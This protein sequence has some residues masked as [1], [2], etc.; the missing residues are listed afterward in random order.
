MFF[1]GHCTGCFSVQC[2]L[3]PLGQHYTRFLSVQCCPK[4]IMTTLH[5][6]FSMSNVVWSLSSNIAHAIYLFNVVPRVLR[7]H[8]KWFFW[9]K[10]GT[11]I[12]IESSIRKRCKRKI[13][14]Y[15]KP[16]KSISYFNNSYVYSIF[17]LLLIKNFFER[18]KSLRAEPKVGG[19]FALE[20]P[21]EML[22]G[23]SRA[24]LHKVF[25]SVIMYQ[26]Y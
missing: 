12:E 14:P 2:C 24:T 1:K 13:F 11:I 22:S 3:E 26:E 6:D 7:Q 15:T 21:L 4:S 25:T 18:N 16:E 10:S 9:V 8:W 5:K 17:T 19:S 20:L 23:A